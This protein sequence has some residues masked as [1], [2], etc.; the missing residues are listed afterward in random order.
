[1]NDDD[2]TRARRDIMLQRMKIDLPSV[3]V[4]ERI[5]HQADVLNLRQKIEQRI[6]WR[7]YQ[8]F[9]A[10]VAERSKDVGIRFAGAGREE[11]V[12]RRNVLFAIGIIPS[13]RAA[14]GF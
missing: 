6:T 14:S 13:D 4:K 12:L 8:E 5:A 3:I 9:I 2:P 11:N 10:R 1:M 7:R